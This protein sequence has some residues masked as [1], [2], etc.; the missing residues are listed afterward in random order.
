MLFIK[1]RNGYFDDKK[2]WE[3]IS[4]MLKVKM[5]MRLS[6]FVKITRLFNEKNL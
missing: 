5:I 3:K 2:I 4:R 6:S 1:A